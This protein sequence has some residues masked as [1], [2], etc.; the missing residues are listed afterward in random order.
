MNTPTFTWKSSQLHVL[1]QRLLP[2]KEEYVVCRDHEAVAKTI[3]DMAVRGAPAIGCVAAYGMVLAAQNGVCL[4]KAGVILKDSRPTA[5]NLAWAVDR[6]IRLKKS[7][8]P[9][10]LTSS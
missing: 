1:D 7:T 6:M 2:Q 3:K 9:H 8:I 4:G 5:V 10:Y